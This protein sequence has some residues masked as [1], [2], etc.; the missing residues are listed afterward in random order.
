MRPSKKIDVFLG[1]IRDF[2]SMITFSCVKI[3]SGWVFPTCS[4]FGGMKAFF[5][6]QVRRWL[7]SQ[8]SGWVG[9]F[10]H[11]Y[12]RTHQ[13]F[14]LAIPLRSM[15]GVSIRVSFFLISLVLAAK[16]RSSVEPFF[17]SRCNTTYL[18]EQTESSHFMMWVYSF[19]RF[20]GT[21]SIICRWYFD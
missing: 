8:V 17:L 15:T 19:D 21:N 3:R 5:E 11:V 14:M 6:G 16:M 18:D 9:W 10:L 1:R 4:F 12:E 2:Y 13:T 7:F 20:K